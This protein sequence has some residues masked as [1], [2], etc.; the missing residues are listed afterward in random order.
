MH[1]LMLSHNICRVARE[2]LG[3]GRRLLK[4][5]VEC[6]P[7]CGV[8]GEALEACFELTAAEA[9]VAGARLELRMLRAAATCPGCDAR[10]DVG[11]MW[12]VCPACGYV[13]VTVD[14]GRE[15]RVAE[16]EVDDV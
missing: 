11:S 1:E 12:D 7:L 4:V 13:P 14:G 9:G 5:V 3:P 10:F 8:V 16:I 6:G 2:H 15:L